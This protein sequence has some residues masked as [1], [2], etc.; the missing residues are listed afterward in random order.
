[1]TTQTAELFTDYNGEIHEGYSG[2]NMYGEDTTGV[3]FDSE[4][5][6]YKTIAEIF[7]NCMEDNNSA[8]A[9][10]TIQYLKNVRTDSMGQ[11]IIYY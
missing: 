1:M 5:D 10:L 2:R 7:Q 11:R 9:D 4:R 3:V 8:D 6:F